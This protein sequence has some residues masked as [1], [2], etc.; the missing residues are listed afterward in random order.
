MAKLQ[1]TLVR[2]LIG[3]PETHRKTVNTL[4]LRKL[5]QTVVQNDSPAIRGMVNQVTHL[6]EVKEIEA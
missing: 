1:I 2:S 4:G 5:N 6:V 3:R